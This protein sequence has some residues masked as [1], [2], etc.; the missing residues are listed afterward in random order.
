MCAKAR[1]KFDLQKTAFVQSINFT[2]ALKI[3]HCC[4]LPRLGHLEFGGIYYHRIGF[5]VHTKHSHIFHMNIMY[6]YHPEGRSHNTDIFNFKKWH[7]Q[8]CPPWLGNNRRVFYS[9]CSGTGL[10]ALALA[11]A[12]LGLKTNTWKLIWQG[13]NF[14]QSF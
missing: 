3:L 2:Q 4:R 7:F 6:L 9:Y 11:V 13:A 10:T 14:S 5:F 12:E 1:Q 8:Y